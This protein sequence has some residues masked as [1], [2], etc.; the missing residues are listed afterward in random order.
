MNMKTAKKLFAVILIAVLSL[1]VIIS[2]AYVISEADHNC[3]GAD[4]P[5]SYPPD[6]TEITVTGVF[7]SYKEGT[8]TYY[9]I[10]D[11]EMTY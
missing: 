4:S 9:H 10:A 5:S 11:A 2:S 3:T 6:N 8:Q 1:S 7:E